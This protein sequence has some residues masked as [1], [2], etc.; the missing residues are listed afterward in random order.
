M[1]E[2][3]SNQIEPFLVV[4]NWSLAPSSVPFASK[5]T[6]FFVHF[7]TSEAKALQEVKKMINKPV[8]KKYLETIETRL[9]KFR[10]Y[11]I[12]SDAR[13]SDPFELVKDTDTSMSPVERT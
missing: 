13:F 2:T 10:S 4:V 8:L 1:A 11:I 7:E 12:C 9:W 5:S 6:S 3:W